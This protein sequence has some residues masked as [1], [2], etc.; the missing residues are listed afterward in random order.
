MRSLGEL[1]SDLKAGLSGKKKSKIGPVGEAVNILNAV[2]RHA[3]KN[4]LYN[5]SA[6][7]KAMH[8]VLDHVSVLRDTLQSAVDLVNALEGSEEASV[9]LSRINAFKMNAVKARLHQYVPTEN[10]PKL[11]ALTPKIEVIQ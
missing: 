4:N 2:I 1:F 5:S 9:V 11:E 7:F 8:I 10:I 3:L 6:T